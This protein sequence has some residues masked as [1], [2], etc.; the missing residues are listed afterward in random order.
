MF[1][2]RTIVEAYPHKAFFQLLNRWARR[3][4]QDFCKEALNTIL[5]MNAHFPGQ[6]IIQFINESRTFEVRPITKKRKALYLTYCAQRMSDNKNSAK[7][8]R[9]FC[10]EDIALKID[11]SVRL[12]YCGLT[13]T[14]DMNLSNVRMSSVNKDHKFCIPTSASA[15]HNQVD[16]TSPTISFTSPPLLGYHLPYSFKRRIWLNVES[17]SLAFYIF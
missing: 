14:H 12:M 10:A 2:I 9:Q 1:L 11:I 17:L 7:Q 4:K 3:K 8:Y 6:T 5:A 15:S 13:G 16:L